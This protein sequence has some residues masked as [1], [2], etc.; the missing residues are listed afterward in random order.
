MKTREKIAWGL[1]GIGVIGFFVSF[2]TL[3]NEREACD[4]EKLEAG[5]MLFECGTELE[6]MGNLCNEESKAYMERGNLLFQCKQTLC[7]SAGWSP[8][9]DW[10]EEQVMQRQAE[11][12]NE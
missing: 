5:E 6:E 3:S 10:E 1:A 11:R 7:K 2:I 8:P 9:A 12:A 4:A